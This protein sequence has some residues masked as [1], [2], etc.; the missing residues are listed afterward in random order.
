MNDLK[1][2]FIWNFHGKKCV[3]FNLTSFDFLKYD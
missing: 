1:Q 3:E 2:S